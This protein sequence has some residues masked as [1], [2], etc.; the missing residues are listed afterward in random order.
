MN[1]L[2]CVH[3]MEKNVIL[4]S[5]LGIMNQYDCQKAFSEISGFTLIRNSETALLSIM[6]SI[7]TTQVAELVR[8]MEFVS[9]YS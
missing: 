2:K 4:M 3:L 6:T 7:T 1:L 8:C 9:F 5:E